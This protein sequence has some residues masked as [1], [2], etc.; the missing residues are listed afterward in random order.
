MTESFI[1][2]VT[3]KY[4]TLRKTDTNMKT[5]AVSDIVTVKLTVNFQTVIVIYSG[6][7]RG[8]D[9]AMIVTMTVIVRLQ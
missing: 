8:S 2:R 7:E 9:S 4:L 3:T 1:E 6:W 5:V